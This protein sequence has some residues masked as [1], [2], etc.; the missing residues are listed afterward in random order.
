[1]KKYLSVEEVQEREFMAKRSG[2]S[3]IEP[4]E[5][6]YVGIFDDKDFSQVSSYS[7]E[8]SE[9]FD[10]LHALLQMGLEDARD[11]LRYMRQEEPEQF[12]K[13]LKAAGIAA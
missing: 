13:L 8:R 3:V 11:F 1:M 5:E 2:F 10:T 7:F 6:P 4:E 9:A 12:E